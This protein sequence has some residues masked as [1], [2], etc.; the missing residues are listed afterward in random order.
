[1]PLACKVALSLA[2]GGQEGRRRIGVGD[3]RRDEEEMLHPGGF[4]R[5]DQVAV[6]LQVHGLRVV[7]PAAAGRVGG[8]QHR[9]DAL[10]GSVK[11]GPLL[12]I[13]DCQLGACLGQRLVI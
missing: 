2:L 13:A 4:G 11:R 5:L 3:Q 7:V 1:M 9:L 8:G 10:A 12:E 6:A